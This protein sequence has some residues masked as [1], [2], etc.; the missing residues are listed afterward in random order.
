MKLGWKIGASFAYAGLFL[1]GAVGLTLLQ[2]GA[3]G[4]L[5]RSLGG[6]H[7]PAAQAGAELLAGLHH[8]QSALRAEMLVGDG[9]YATECETAW[10]DEVDTALARLQEAVGQDDD[11]QSMV[12][13]EE[14][15]RQLS[16]VR[17]EQKRIAGLGGEEGTPTARFAEEQDTVAPLVAAIEAHVEELVAGATASMAEDLEGAADTTDRLALLEWILLAVGL[18]TFAI[19]T[20][21][22]TRHLR[23]P[24]RR[25]CRVLSDLA[26]GNMTQRLEMKRRDEL[27]ELADSYDHAIQNLAE[28][29][30]KVRTGSEE[31]DRGSDQISSSSQQLS[32][33]ATESA[34]S[35]E[36][37]SASLEEISSMVQANSE[38]S[39]KANHLS[40][41][42]STVAGK[43][44]AE[45]ANMVEAMNDI[46]SSSAEIA[47][48][49]NVI[50]EIAFQTNLLALNAAV[51]AARAGEAG[52]GFAVV[53]EEV[54]SLAKRSADAA[55]DTS[56]KIET[57]TR[58]ARNGSDIAQRVGESLDEIVGSVKNVNSI[59]QEIASASVEQSRGIEQ[60]T[61]GVTALDKVTQMTAANA[62]EL[63]ATSE[64][65]SGQVSSLRALL[66]QFRFD[67]DAPQAAS[68]PHAHAHAPRAPHA[69]PES[70]RFSRAKMES[71]PSLVKQRSRPS[72]APTASAAPG[73][74]P[75]ND[76]E[77]AAFGFDEDGDDHRLANNSELESF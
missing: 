74:I 26:A 13:L 2:I 46:S 22:L 75:M 48:I 18:G 66:D 29:M 5:T 12:R 23:E 39:Q 37:I 65:S 1:I 61:Q 64:E 4:D 57:A 31:I 77:E 10:A 42:A 60:V 7:A 44:A 45:M 38:S 47:K 20:F 35:L 8:A 71:V 68:E 73:F 24:I 15:A 30:G 33:S 49:I 69:K 52:K 51:E 50:D 9:S 25:T 6:V 63:A 55:R 62:E 14:A 58:S 3:V 67:A 36:E 43:G 32:A 70:P 41:E 34:S 17:E 19:A 28:M 40:D 27:G 53:A 72:L 59:L 54:R 11:P 16:S 21:T 76:D 56:V